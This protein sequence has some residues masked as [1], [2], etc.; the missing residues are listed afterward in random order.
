MQSQNILRILVGGIIT[1]LAV[2]LLGLAVN[3]G[4]ALLA[5]GVK[6]VLVLLLVAI[7]VRFMTLLDDKRNLF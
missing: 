2:M 1:V 7:V 6:A 5:L 3:L 4:G